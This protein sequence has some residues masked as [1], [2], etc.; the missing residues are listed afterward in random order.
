MSEVAVLR[1]RAGTALPLRRRGKSSD[2]RRRVGRHRAALRGR[3]TTRGTV[4]GS[5]AADV[6]SIE[7]AEL[8]AAPWSRRLVGC[9]RRAKG[10]V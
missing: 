10:P 1:V 4:S 5:D 7:P 3:G 8:S 2:V 6:S 9:A